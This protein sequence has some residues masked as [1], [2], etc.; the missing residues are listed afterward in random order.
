M[1]YSVVLRLSP[2]PLLAGRLA[3]E[4]E[5]VASGRRGVIASSDELVEFV[6]G[7]LDAQPPVEHEEVQ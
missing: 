1:T 2:E 4:V 5:A 6:R 3:G 7:E